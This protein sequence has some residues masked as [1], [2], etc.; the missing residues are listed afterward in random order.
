MKTDERSTIVE[1]GHAADADPLAEAVRTMLREVGEDPE[2]EGVLKTPERVA[3][4]LWFLT[5][6]YRQDVRELLNGA[7]FSV[8]YDEMVIVK[9]VEIFS[10]CEHHLLPFLGRCQVAD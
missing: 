6:G 4:S 10:M 3:K 1:S 5:G 9:D 7:V 8:V 2:R